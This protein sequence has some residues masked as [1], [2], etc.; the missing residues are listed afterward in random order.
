MSNTTSLPCQ[1][2]LSWNYLGLGASKAIAEGI[3]VSRSLTRLLIKNNNIGDEGCIA[4]AE[5]MQQNDSHKIEELSLFNNQIGAA[6]AKSLAAMIAVSRFLTSVNVSMNDITGDGAQQLADAALHKP[7]LE[8][9]CAIP[10]KELRADSV[11]ELNLNN[12]VVGVPGALVIA[13]FLRVSYSLTCLRIGDNHIGDEDCAAL[14]EAML[15]NDSCKIEELGLSDNRIEVAGAKS[16]AAMIAV[17]RSLSK[18][19][20][21]SF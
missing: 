7:S 14:A 2:D 16:L 3:R 12:H 1:V 21:S 6:G 5:A 15:Q 9:F 20:P 18:V 8:S 10:L 19:F 11:S 4:L 17:S 13:H